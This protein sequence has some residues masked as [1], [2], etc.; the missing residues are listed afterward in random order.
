MPPSVPT[1]GIEWYAKGGIMTA[2]TMFGV[3]GGRAM[4]GGEAGPEAVLPISLLQDYID[5]AFDRNQVGNNNE[6]NVTVYASGDSDD[7]ANKV[8]VKVFGAIDQ[9]MAANGR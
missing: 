5:H 1:I 9:A 7:I 8:A 3:N 2:P 4:V 6:V